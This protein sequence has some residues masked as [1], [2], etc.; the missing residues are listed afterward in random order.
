VQVGKPGFFSLL[1]QNLLLKGAL[2]ALLALCASCSGD[3]SAPPLE[4]VSWTGEDQQ[5]V[6]LD[7]VLKIEFNQALANP[8]RA[9][10]LQMFD[11]GH[12]VVENMTAKVV[13]RWIYITPMLPKNAALTDGSL[14]PAHNYGIQ[15][16]GLPWLR[17][18]ASSGGTLLEKDLILPFRT[19]DADSPGALAGRGVESSGLRLEGPGGR[20]PV[21]FRRGEK[22]LLHFTRG[23]DPRSVALPARWRVQG[24]EHAVEVSMR[25]LENR[26]DGSILEVMLEDWRGAGALELPAGIEGLGGWPFPESERVIHLVRRAQ[27]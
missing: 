21:T 9:S 14:L 10:S 7:Q 18:L 23:I 16:S 26:I 20:E 17:A 3:E 24:Q 2:T 1:P 5:P 25:L 11:E 13:G 4:V 15:L 27:E 8:M 6:A 22:V 19:A 12:Y